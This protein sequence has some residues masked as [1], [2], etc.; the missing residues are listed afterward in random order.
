MR[1]RAPTIIHIRMVVPIEDRSAT[2]SG[3]FGGPAPDAAAV[4]AD[5]AWRITR[6][7]HLV[8]ALGLLLER[9]R[10]SSPAFGPTVF[11]NLEDPA[12]SNAVLAILVESTAD[13]RRDLNAIRRGVRTLAGADG[14]TFDH[15]VVRRLPALARSA[16]DLTGRFEDYR[17]TIGDGTLMRSPSTVAR[18]HQVVALSVRSLLDI[19]EV[20]DS[21]QAEEDRLDLAPATTS[22]PPPVMTGEPE[23]RRTPVAALAVPLAAAFW[24]GIG[25]RRTRLMVEFAGV[26]VVG[27]VVLISALGQGGLPPDSNPSNATSSAEPGRTAGEVAIASDAPSGSPP[28]S[29]GPTATSAPP[30]PGPSSAAPPPPRATPRLTPAPTHRAVTA[31]VT[32]FADHITAAAGSIDG[33][34]GTIATEVQDGDFAAATNAADGIAAIALTERSWL[35][36]HPAKACYRPYHQLAMATYGELL[37]SAATIA[38]DAAAGDANSIHNDVAH[39]HLE[40][41]TLK[42]AGAKAVIAC[43]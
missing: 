28:P 21:L 41:S 3:G 25:R 43:A 19:R 31:A 8:A 30:P 16:A 34:L 39:S 7:E 10:G 38:T 2:E 29:A 5:L 42:Q 12:A 26:V 20:V 14:I 1:L 36:S 32:R 23:R 35:L 22:Q 13:A 24:R 6:L 17:S 15:P 11:D 27:F 33:L 9:F 40:V 4:E 18:L 37:T